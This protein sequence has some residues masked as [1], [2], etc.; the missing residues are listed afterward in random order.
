MPNRFRSVIAFLL[1][2]SAS[3]AWADDYSVTAAKLANAIFEG[4]SDIQKELLPP[5][6]KEEYAELEKLAGCPATVRGGGAASFVIFDWRCPADHPS[7]E[8]ARSTAVRFNE[9]GRLIGFAINRTLEGAQPTAIAQA[10]SDLPS[11]R[12]LLRAFAEAVVSGGDATLDG[13][14]YLDSFDEARLAPYV[15]GSFRLSRTM[16]AGN[17]SIYLYKNKTRS[18]GRR[19][20]V[21]QLDDAGRPLG[22]TF[23]PRYVADRRSS[24]DDDRTYYSGIRNRER[25][26]QSCVGKT[27]C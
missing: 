18:G 27:V 5:L 22:L 12:P 3:T 21:L 25:S 10:R 14:I 7:G 4:Q 15:G 16:V 11:V 20:A 6:S 13:L 9:D 1:L 2:V 19:T 26:V 23:G 17:F 8:I 24:D